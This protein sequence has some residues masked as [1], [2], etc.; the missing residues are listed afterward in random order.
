MSRLT[1]TNEQRRRM[2]E[3]YE[4]GGCSLA[5]LS[6]EFS[7]SVPTVSRIL[8]SE[9][10]VIRPRGRPRSTQTQSSQNEVLVETADTVEVEEDTTNDEDYPEIPGVNSEPETRPV[11]RF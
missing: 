1:L 9:G 8:R 10:A 2:R 4:L 11:F 7:V 3:M 5:K 6:V